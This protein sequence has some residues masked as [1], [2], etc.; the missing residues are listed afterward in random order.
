MSCE[1]TVFLTKSSSGEEALAE[2]EKLLQMPTARKTAVMTPLRFAMG[3]R[4]LPLQISTAR[5]RDRAFFGCFCPSLES[6]GDIGDP[7]PL[8]W[9][10]E[11]M[12]KVWRTRESCLLLKGSKKRWFD[13]E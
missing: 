12:M 6:D 2:E 11:E 8:R 5:K 3:S 13:L 4:S 1:E 7:K 10:F 9:A